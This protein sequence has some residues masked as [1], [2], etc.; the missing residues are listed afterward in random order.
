MPL[1]GIY[2]LAGGGVDSDRLLNQWP[3]SL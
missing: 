3:L 1:L 2:E